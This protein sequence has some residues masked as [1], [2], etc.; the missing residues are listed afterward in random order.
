MDQITPKPTRSAAAWVAAAL[1]LVLSPAAHALNVDANGNAI[2]EPSVAPAESVGALS[3]AP[4][5]ANVELSYGTVAQSST[6]VAGGGDDEA[7]TLAKQL[8]NPIS[9]LISVPFQANEDC[10]VNTEST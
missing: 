3:N 1:G 10:G 4:F 6:P 8:A 2:G 9:S 7:D 5:E